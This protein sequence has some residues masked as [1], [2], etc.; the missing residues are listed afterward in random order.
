MG[1]SII[2]GS[3]R[4]IPDE[5]IQ[6]KDFVSQNFYTE[7]YELINQ[8]SEIVIDKFKKITGIEERRYARQDVTSSDLA[9]IAARIA[10]E[11]SKIDPESLDQIIFAHN[12]GDVVKHTIQVDAVPSLAARVKH[13]L[14]IANPNCTAYDLLFGCPGWLQGIIH[15]D[16]FFKAGIAKRIMVIGSET[17]S[18]VVDP[19]DRD[20]MI[21]SDGAG[22]TILEYNADVQNRGIIGCASQSFTK[23]EAFYIYHGKSNF[24]EADPKV[25]F[26]K[27]KG[28]KVYEFALKHVPVAMKSCLDQ[29]NI[30]IDQLKKVFIHQANEK[31]DEAII[32]ELYK[33]YGLDN[34]PVDIMPMSIHK[35]GNSSVATIPTLYDLVAKGD[36]QCHSLAAG[37]VILF[38]SVGA[39]MHINAVAYRV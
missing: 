22:V 9:T 20:S 10:L 16:A 39:G 12:Y 34:I 6:N 32:R 23:E 13:N 2:I 7:S 25:R 33:L 19:Y 26:I 37:D 35:L 21:F 38:A 11:D 31:M 28:R 14:G 17:L 36:L 29:C 18:R 3:G 8:P 24:P 5:V 1:S 27:M 15:S 30:G 4:C